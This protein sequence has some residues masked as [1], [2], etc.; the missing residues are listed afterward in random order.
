M[1]KLITAVNTTSGPVEIGFYHRYNTEANY[2]GG[3]VEY[4][5]NGGTTWL[6]AG[7]YFTENGYP[8]S[9]YTAGTN[10]PIAGRPAFT[11]NSDVQFNATGFIHSTIRLTLGGPQSLLVRFRMTCDAGVAGTG[12]NGWHVDDIVIKQ[13]SGLTNKTRVVDNGQ[14][15]DSLYYALQTSMFSGH[16]IYI[17]PTAVGNLSGGGWAN[18][19][20]FLPM[21]LGITGCRST[22]SILVAQGTFMPSL[23][24]SRLQSFTIPDSTSIYGGFPSGGSTFALRNPVTHLTLLSGDIGV[25]NDMSDNSYHVVKIDSSKQSILLDGFTISH[26]NA[27]GLGNNSFG[28]AV[29]CLGK[30][31]LQNVTIINNVGMN[32][33]ELIRIRSAVA[34]LKLKDCTL[35]GPEDGKVKV[36]NTNSAQLIIEGNTMIIEQ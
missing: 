22:D 31:T 13:L 7:P 32:D 4:S 1:L 24:N 25:P 5:V 35:Y 8:A 27:N 17:D 9:I 15:V 18:A 29:F 30:L 19:M 6:D 2:D 3:V 12:I 33:G 10:S 11:G 23:I 34:Q 26:G 28:A 36:L 14:L 16:K 21:A 20:H